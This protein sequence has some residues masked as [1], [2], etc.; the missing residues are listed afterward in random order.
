MI[1][2]QFKDKGFNPKI[3]IIYIILTLITGISTGMGLVVGF[4]TY[5][6]IGL[7]VSGLPLIAMLLYSPLRLR[8]LKA[9]YRRQESEHLFN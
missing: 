6:T 9:Q 3:A 7:T 1:L 8:Q 5:L 4:T 2:A